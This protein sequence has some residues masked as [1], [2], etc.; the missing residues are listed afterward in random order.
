MLQ[1]LLVKLGI[2]QSC[3]DLLINEYQDILHN[4]IVRTVRYSYTTEN[5]TITRHLHI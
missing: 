1:V 4:S 2:T 5:K 3:I